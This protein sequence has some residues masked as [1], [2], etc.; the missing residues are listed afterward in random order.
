MK[1]EEIYLSHAIRSGIRK[2]L[3]YF[4][5]ILKYDWEGTGWLTRHSREVP[6]PQS[7]TK[8]SSKQLHFEQTFREK[9]PKVN[10]EVM[11]TLKLKEQEVG[12]PQSH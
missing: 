6:L 11:Q 3:Y 12:S 5:I 4:S 1:K 2:L 7:E 8:I 10:R 9:T